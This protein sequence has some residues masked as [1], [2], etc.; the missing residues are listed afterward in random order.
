M[1]ASMTISTQ[2]YLSVG[3]GTGNKKH[4]NEVYNVSIRLHLIVGALLSVSMFAIT[5]LLFGGILNIESQSLL[6]AKFLYFILIGNL[7]FT[8]IMVPFDAVLN[9]YENMLVFS[10][11]CIIE[12]ILRLTLALCLPHLKSNLLLWYGCGIML[13]TFLVLLS[14]AVYVTLHY[15]DLRITRNT[16]PKELFNEMFKFAGWNLLG[17]SAI[18][19]RNQGVAIILNI[20]FGT[21][22]NAAYGIANQINGVLNYFSSAL[23]KSI[24]PQLM[25]SEGMHDRQ[26]MLRIAFQ[27]SKFSTLLVGIIAIPLLAEMPY[28]LK[29]W[30]TDVPEHTIHF[31]RIII[32]MSL[33]TLFSSGI[34]SAVQSVGKIKWYFICISSVLLSSLPIIYFLLKAKSNPDVALLVL[35]AIEV[36]ALLVRL[37]FAKKLA[38]FDSKKFILHIFIPI[39]LLFFIDLLILYGIKFFVAMSFAR[40]ILC[41]I[42]HLIVTL[43]IIWYMLLNKQERTT[44]TNLC[45][46][47]YDSHIKR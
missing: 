17:S 37:I 32:I 13:I 7:M 24:T 26:R 8:I 43:P 22:I 14:K 20:F 9:A 41:T 30:L 12:S 46:S 38:D 5:P 34:M 6:T 36:I 35:L 25:Q 3:M 47:V 45:K 28:I 33:L 44:I 11:I 19:G 23:Q 10:I 29:M 4:L 18:I 15:K 27:S 16:P 39:S 1:N 31:S 40:L 42:T 2:R 21:V